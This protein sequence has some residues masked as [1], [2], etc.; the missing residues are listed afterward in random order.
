MGEEST[1]RRVAYLDS[2]LIIPRETS[3]IRISNVIIRKNQGF[4]DRQKFRFFGLKVGLLSENEIIT[5]R[6]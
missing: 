3:I 5:L 2:G 1:P 4:F 6:E